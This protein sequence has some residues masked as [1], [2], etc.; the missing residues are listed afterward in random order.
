MTVVVSRKPD[1]TSS[2]KQILVTKKTLLSVGQ[3]LT[4]YRFSLDE[5]WRLITGSVHDLPRP[6]RNATRRNS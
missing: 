5:S 4:V 3:E 1:K 6:L 2:A